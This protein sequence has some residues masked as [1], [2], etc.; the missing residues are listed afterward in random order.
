MAS[1]AILKPDKEKFHS[2][3]HRTQ[4]HLMGLQGIHIQALFGG[5]VFNFFGL[6][7]GLKI[8]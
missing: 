1:D 5:P 3:F 8:H 6:H 7:P 2:C 4:I